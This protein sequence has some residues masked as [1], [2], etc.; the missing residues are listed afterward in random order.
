MHNTLGKC[1]FILFIF[2]VLLIPMNGI[3]SAMDATLTWSANTDTILAGYKIYYGTTSRKYNTP[4][5][6]GKQIS[7]VLTNLP[8]QIHFF[9]VTSYDTGGHESAFS[10]E[11]SKAPSP[12]ITAPL[13]SSINASSI[14]SAVATITWGTNEGANTQVQYGTTTSYGS[15]TTLISALVTVHSQA[16]TGL[17]PTTLYHYRVLSRDAAGNLATSLDNSFTTPAA[18][19]TTAPAMPTGLKASTVSSSQVNLTW[20]ASTDNVKA[21]GYRIYRNGAQVGTSATT[22]YLD[23]GL[24][25]STTYNYSLSAYDAAGNVSAQTAAVSAATLA[26]PDTAAPALSAIAAGSIT[27]GGATITWTSSE[28]ADTQ[29]EYGTTLAYGTT[30]VVLPTKVTAHSQSLTGLLSATLYHYRVKSKDAAGNLAVSA[31]AT[32]TTATPADTTPPAVPAGLQ[33]AAASSTQI[34]LTWTVSTDNV[35]VAGYRVYRNGTQVG[36]TATASYAD[37][38]LVAS[39]TYSYT[40]SAYDAAGNASAQTSAVSVKT[41]AAPDTTAP[42]LSGIGTT[43]ITSGGATVGWTTNEPAT[44]QVEYGATATYGLL[45]TLNST[46]ATSHSV[47]LTGLSASTVYHYRVISRDGAG[48]IATSGDNTF[49]TALPPD[50]TAPVISGIAA[51]NI[52]PGGATL[53]WTTNES[54]DTQVEYG[55][56]TAYGSATPIVSN[57]VTAH[58]QSLTGLLSATLYHYRVK[59]KDA[60]GNLAVSSD[61]TFTTATP[62]DTAAPSVPAGLSATAASAGQI[63]LA[64]SASTDNVKVTGYRVYRNG[65]QV[66]TAALP[67]YVDSGLTAAT[68]YSYTVSAYDA[69]GNASAQT[70]AVSA[71]TLP[72]PDTTAPTLS[73][74][75]ISGVTPGGATVGWTTNEPATTQVEYGTTTAYGT[76]STLNTTLAA[77]H[78]VALTGLS[79]STTYHYRLLSRDAA[80]NLATSGDNSFTTAAPP[81]T[82]PPVISGMGAGSVTVNSAVIGWSTNEPADTQIEYGT[83]TTYGSFTAVVST[84]VTSHAQ[85]V[86]GL[87]PST[88]YH[89]RVRS[90][91]AA[92]NLTISGD[93]T[94]TTAMPPDTTAP[95]VPNGLSASAVSSS[96]INLSWSASTD[97]VKVAGYRIYRNGAQIA[98]TTSTSYSNTGLS[99][100]TTYRY[101]VSAYD[102]AGNVSNQS[103]SR[104][105]TTDRSRWGGR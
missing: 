1:G 75:G 93:G 57:R 86:S 19:D 80:G 66:G 11:V 2:M 82:T 94:F 90:R 48:N 18:P 101:T 49:T 103:A 33:A 67:S 24:A 88:L 59:S 60:A 32:F 22:S 37:S 78:S 6:V 84:L 83:T 16:L 14:T 15:S 87:N 13:I 95:S 23:T 34:N 102:A 31:D 89:Y 3:A 53:S 36:T 92:G 55:T 62:P 27:T 58:S 105:A 10:A 25:S 41:S 73:G 17:Q 47:A 28:A 8:N 40:I 63:N 74:I 98:T 30:T 97:N 29:V 76:L 7:Y 50:T 64:W 38:G 100:N 26:A 104:S 43:G 65:T 4:I 72:P 61:A 81:D 91:D 52:T 39:T 79:P 56:T 21:I 44:T 46:L 45:S 35:K 85:S 96:Q 51:G 99:E 5:D 20:T 12:D 9:A 42:V 68:T 71:K 77:S 54:S 69:A 70:Q